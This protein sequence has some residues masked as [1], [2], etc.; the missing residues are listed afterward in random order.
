MH[1][2]NASDELLNGDVISS[3]SLR[4]DLQRGRDRVMIRKRWFAY[5]SSSMR[6]A[7]I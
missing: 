2:I 3:L 5:I 4:P 6:A 7:G 1:N